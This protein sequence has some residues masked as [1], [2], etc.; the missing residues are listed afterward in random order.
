MCLSPILLRCAGPFRLWG[1]GSIPSLCNTYISKG[2]P[3]QANNSLQYANS[4]L[5]RYSLFG[6]FRSRSEGAHGIECNA[7]Y[8]PPITMARKGLIIDSHRA[9]PLVL[10]LFVTRRSVARAR[11]GGPE[12]GRTRGPWNTGARHGRGYAAKAPWAAP[13]GLPGPPA[14][15]RSGG[16]RTSGVQAMVRDDPRRVAFGARHAR[17]IPEGGIAPLA[18]VPPCG[19]KPAPGIV[20]RQGGDA[21]PWVIMP[22]PAGGGSA[23]DAAGWETPRGGRRGRETGAARLREAEP[24]RARCRAGTAEQG[25]RRRP[26]PR[27]S[28]LGIAKSA[29]IGT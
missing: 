22:R 20:T 9:H 18:S 27:A 25:P 14:R 10:R 11:Q 13:S 21:R 24:T 2:A 28:C 5:D 23:G 3:L 8:F 7:F 16:G 1:G 17:R 15:D 12:G 4:F 6:L 29:S 26:A 19:S